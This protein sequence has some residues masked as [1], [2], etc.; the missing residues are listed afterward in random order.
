MDKGLS[1]VNLDTYAY[2]FIHVHSSIYEYMYM[3]VCLYVCACVY[4]CGMYG[5]QARLTHSQQA[6][7]GSSRR[8]TQ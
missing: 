4:V 1:C 6:F 5:Q 8:L 3:N 2:T 7:F